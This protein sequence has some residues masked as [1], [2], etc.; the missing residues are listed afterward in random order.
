MSKNHKHM[1]LA[2]FIANEYSKD[3]ST[4]VGCVV[5]GPGD[6]VLST[7]YN[8]IARGV[9]DDVEERHQ[10]PEKYKWFEHAE[11]NAIFNAA[12]N[13]IKLQGSSIYVTSL[14][15]CI[16]CA[17]GIIQSG[18]SALYLEESAFSTSNERGQA[19]IDQWT[20]SKRM[21][22][23]SG[24]KVYMVSETSTV[25]IIPSVIPTNYYA[26]SLRVGPKMIKDPTITNS[27]QA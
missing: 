23:E 10:R 3:R 22:D 24:V 5:I 9:K 7:G 21:F 11:R 19:W 8:G 14:I 6:N 1:N 12:R 25:Q 2:R 15:T 4:K 27:I 26:N 13:G 18:I 16:D 20:T 17:R